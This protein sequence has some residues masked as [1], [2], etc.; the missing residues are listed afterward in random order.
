[1]TVLR[2]QIVDP[3]VE[4]SLDQIHKLP[5]LSIEVLRPVR[6][7]AHPRDTAYKGHER[8]LVQAYTATAVGRSMPY[9]DGYRTTHD[10]WV[11][12]MW[13]ELKAGDV[14]RLRADD[15]SLVDTPGEHAVLYAVEDARFD[16][17]IMTWA[18]RADPVYVVWAVRDLGHP[19][20][21][22]IMSY[23]QSPEA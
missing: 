23:H 21:T 11:P 1:M 7:E 5:L 8:H 15:G 22:L 12:R 18:V 17:D 20:E 4:R 13:E 16:E 10:L 2:T 3:E 9:T 19:M 6:G 14:F